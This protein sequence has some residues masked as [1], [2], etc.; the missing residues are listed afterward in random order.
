[1]AD[2]WLQAPLAHIGD[3]NLVGLRAQRVSH[4]LQLVSGVKPERVAVNGLLGGAGG[5]QRSGVRALEV[6]GGLRCC[7]LGRP[8]KHVSVRG[9]QLQW[10]RTLQAVWASMYDLVV[11]APLASST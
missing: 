10:A 5:R 9:I 11:V 7:H 1:M 3:T 2:L 4:R 8:T 6:R